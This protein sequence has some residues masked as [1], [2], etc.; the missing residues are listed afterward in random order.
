MP[1]PTITVSGETL[2][3]TQWQPCR[4]GHADFESADLVDAASHPP[5]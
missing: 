4:A 5:T 3:R 2:A 1:R